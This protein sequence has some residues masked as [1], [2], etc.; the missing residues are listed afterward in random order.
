MVDGR[1]EEKPAGQ[2]PRISS[3]QL[4]AVTSAI[5]HRWIDSTHPSATD[6]ADTATGE[7]SSWTA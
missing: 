2:K 3:E 4:A 1:F 5:V 7:A 6:G